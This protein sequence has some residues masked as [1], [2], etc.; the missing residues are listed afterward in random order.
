MCFYVNKTLDYIALKIDELLLIF[1]HTFQKR[2]WTK[3]Q[4]AEENTTRVV[5]RCGKQL[6]VLFM[7]IAARSRTRVLHTWETRIDHGRVVASDKG[8]GRGH[9]TVYTLRV[10][11]ILGLKSGPVM[12]NV[13]MSLTAWSAYSFLSFLSFLLLDILWSIDVAN[14]NERPAQCKRERNPVQASGMREPA[15]AS[16]GALHR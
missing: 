15:R 7:S 4:D 5:C 3:R 6:K 2:W 1:Q 12:Q 8:E 16:S 14:G 11:C 10:R 9:R 13:R